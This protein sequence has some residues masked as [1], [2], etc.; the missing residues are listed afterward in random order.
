MI[1]DH[2]D[3]NGPSSST[4]VVSGIAAMLGRSGPWTFARFARFAARFAA[5]GF[6]RLAG[7]AG[8]TALGTFAGLRCLCTKLTTPVW[9][10]TLIVS[11]IAAM[12]SPLLLAT[13]ITLPRFALARLARLGR[14]LVT[15]FVLSRATGLRYL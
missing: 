4:L 10:G 5:A 3:A 8:L 11:G 1:Q 15:T 13:L 12:I 2:V 6:A 9:S 7:L 14:H